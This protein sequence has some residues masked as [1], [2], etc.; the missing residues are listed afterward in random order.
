MRNINGLW[1]IQ[2]TTTGILFMGAFAQ[3]SV[4]AMGAAFVCSLVLRWKLVS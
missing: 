3:D 2:A 1:W 4:I